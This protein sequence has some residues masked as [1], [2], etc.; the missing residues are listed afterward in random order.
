MNT[1]HIKH[2]FQTYISNPNDHFA[3]MLNGAWGSGKTYFWEHELKPIAQS[4][5]K[6]ILYISLNGV[7]TRAALEHLMFM[8]MI[9]F[10]SDH[11]SKR[12]TQLVQL[13]GNIAG[14][15]AKKKLDISLPD[16]FKGLSLDSI[17]YTDYLVCFDDLERCRM[18]L[19]E[20]LG[21]IN[22][23]VE[24][25]Q[26][27][28]ILLADETK[29]DEGQ[30]TYTSIKEK[31]IGRTINFHLDHNLILPRLLERHAANGVLF[32]FFQSKQAYLQS[33]F[34]AFN[35]D[36]L[37]IIAFSLS[38]IARFHPIMAE[39]NEKS[40]DDALLCAITISIDFKRG[41]LN[42]QDEGDFKQLQM[43]TLVQQFWSQPTR[44]ADTTVSDIV[45]S[46]FP[47][48]FFE[49][50]LKKL[51]RQ[52]DL[53]ES[54]YNYILSGYL[55]ELLLAK[56]F[57]QRDPD[58]IPEYQICYP[59]LIN[60]KFRNL[61]NE[62]FSELVIKTKNYAEEG[63]Y[64]IYN[65][66]HIVDFYFYFSDN[67]LCSLSYDEIRDFARKGLAKAALRNKIDTQ[68]FGNIMHFQK[69]NPET[70][71]FKQ[72]IALVHNTIILEQKHGLG[73]KLITYIREGNVDEITKAFNEYKFDKDFLPG[74]NADE[75]TKILDTAPNKSIAQLTIAFE[76][77]YQPTNI[78][79]FLPDDFSSLNL[80]SNCITTISS[81]GTLD[82]LRK[83]LMQE[84]NNAVKQATSRY[85]E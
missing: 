52:F 28:T 61:S 45:K 51:N 79:Q 17:I 27:K 38:I 2:V 78:K 56:E 48:E 15:L 24:H 37:R 3:I 12:K 5:N 81:G 76:E 54:I 47:K 72:E 40:V 20:L 36:N 16:L 59:L 49:R 33:L 42:S 19:P 64:T 53:F 35:E 63:V 75:I 10:L 34:E 77:R 57:E 1:E 60:Y 22:D 29:I 85:K 55:D 26:L 62:E 70:E 14:L 13:I 46:P 66:L 18:P 6:K 69:D 65:Y 71:K 25:K 58:K 80:L 21:F 8:R 41:F 84:L 39:Q 4:A 7:N 67:G 43:L 82:P 83:F 11:T 9:P 31:V 23:F 32:G 30:Q 73:T 74:K 68:D 50:Y 44:D